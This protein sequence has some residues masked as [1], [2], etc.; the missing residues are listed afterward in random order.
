MKR[1]YLL[2]AVISFVIIVLVSVIGFKYYSDKTFNDFKTKIDSDTQ[3]LTAMGVEMNNIGNKVSEQTDKLTFDSNFSK[4]QY[5]TAISSASE[6]WDNLL[7]LDKNNFKTLVSS[8]DTDA[9]TFKKNVLWLSGDQVNYLNVV[10]DSIG[11]QKVLYEKFLVDVANIDFVMK[12]FFLYLSDMTNLFDYTSSSPN[13]SD[14]IKNISKLDALKKYTEAD[15]MFPGETKLKSEFPSTYSFL[16]SF[17]GFFN[18]S[19]TAFNAYAA[20]N[21]QKFLDLEKQIQDFSDKI[22]TLPDPMKEISSKLEKL[23]T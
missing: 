13:P 16:N 21:T 20:G 17:K 2:I 7:N 19:Y 10:S 15:F 22:G 3:K 11:K 14:L 5:D 9:I 6:N 4:Q 8:M 12:A 1:K 23:G 18:I